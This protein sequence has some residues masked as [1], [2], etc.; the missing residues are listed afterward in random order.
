MRV[1]CRIAAASCDSDRPCSGIDQQKGTP[2]CCAVLGHLLA[3]GP[4][5]DTQPL[6]E[7]PYASTMT[8]GAQYTG[9]L[10]QGWAVLDTLRLALGW[11][12]PASSVC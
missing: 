4:P 6:R 3:P 9:G 12:L 10:P 5:C 11:A 7:R 2:Q 1:L 8:A